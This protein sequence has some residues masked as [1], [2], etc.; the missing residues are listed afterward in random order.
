MH[1]FKD[2]EVAIYES[3]LKRRVLR[4]A[5]FNV[6]LVCEYDSDE[7]RETASD[8]FRVVRWWSRRHCGHATMDRREPPQDAIEKALAAVRGQ[9]GYDPER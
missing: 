1:C 9:I 5:L 7:E 8:E 6:S 4:F 2:T 3:D